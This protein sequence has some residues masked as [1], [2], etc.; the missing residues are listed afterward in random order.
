[1]PWSAILG[2]TKRVQTYKPSQ[3]TYLGYDIIIDFNYFVFFFSRLSVIPANWL[4][5]SPTDIR[6]TTVVLVLPRRHDKRLLP[7]QAGPLPL[8]LLAPPPLPVASPLSP[9]SPTSS[10]VP[11]V[12]QT[13]SRPTQEAT[14]PP[15][16]QPGLAVIQQALQVGQQRHRDRPSRPSRRVCRRTRHL[17]PR[18]PRQ[19]PTPPV[20]KHSKLQDWVR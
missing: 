7:R 10:L 19:W 18:L 17:R 2:E 15:Q 1:M 3:P 13:I 4:S 20:N 12:Q 14:P 5:A 8:R 6:T 16:Q 11:S 9:R